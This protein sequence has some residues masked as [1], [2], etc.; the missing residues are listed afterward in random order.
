[1]VLAGRIGILGP[2]HRPLGVRALTKLGC[3]PLRL[4]CVSGRWSSRSAR[5]QPTR[6]LP[7]VSSMSQ[8]APASRHMDQRAR[9]APELLERIVAANGGQEQMD[10]NRTEIEQDPPASRRPLL[11]M[12]D[13][14][15]AALD[16]ANRLIGQ[17]CQ[18]ALAGAGADDEV[19]R[20]TSRRRKVQQENVLPLLLRQQVN[21]R[22][23]QL[24]IVDGA[25]PAMRCSS[26][27]LRPPPRV[28]PR[29]P[30]RQTAPGAR[31]SARRPDSLRPRCQARRPACRP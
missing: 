11:P 8:G 9:A 28:R 12:A 29:R 17:R 21:Q 22:V 16:A 14:V 4:T 7:C 18:R 6:L 20:E 30:R 24:K 27:S 19:V 3:P 25:P 31:A 10:H 2:R 26:G 15:V 13:H 5:E 1:M 23:R